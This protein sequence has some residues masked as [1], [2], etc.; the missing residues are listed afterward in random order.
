MK[1]KFLLLFITILLIVKTTLTNTILEDTGVIDIPKLKTNYF[2]SNNIN[3]NNNIHKIYKL[4]KMEDLPTF[5]EHSKLNEVE[6]LCVISKFL[7][8]QDA[9]I[10]RA[11]GVFDQTNFDG[12]FNT[13]P[14]S[15]PKTLEWNAQRARSAAKL[16]VIIYK[17]I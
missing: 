5:L 8:S 10:I 7:I 13:E 14:I 17:I 3:N 1:F 16:W 15:A 6:G 4:E 11:G 2:L 9:W 12:L